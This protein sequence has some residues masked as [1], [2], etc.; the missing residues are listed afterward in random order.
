MT[1][2]PSPALFSVSV[3]VT[4]TERLILRE[5][6]AGDLD[7]VAEFLASPRATF[8]GGPMTRFESWRNIL[9]VCG[10]WIIRGHGYWTIE[11]AATGCVVGRIGVH[12]HE[13]KWPEPELGWQIFDGFE[14]LGY[15][16]EA[17]L[18]ARAQAARMGLGALISLIAPDNARSRRLAERMGASVEREIDLL[19]KHVLMYR[20]PMEALA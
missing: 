2:A 9:M 1:M 15:A 3:P 11:E 6:R 7:A 13:E 18:A 12:N 4:R 5:P 14:G 8:V 20:H 17:A 16:H 10:H 19:G